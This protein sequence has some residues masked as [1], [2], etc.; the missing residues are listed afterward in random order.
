MV[1]KTKQEEIRE[2]L[3][4]KIEDIRKFASDPDNDPLTAEEQNYDILSYLH[5][6]GVAIKGREH[7][8]YVGN[9]EV[10]PLIEE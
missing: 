4:H 6:R 3:L 9:F 2:G 5:S 10:E 8:S 1:T 7:S